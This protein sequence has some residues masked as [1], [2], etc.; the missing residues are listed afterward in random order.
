MAHMKRLDQL[1]ETAEFRVLL[2]RCFRL[3]MKSL[4]SKIGEKQFSSRRGLVGEWSTELR[5]ASYNYFTTEE[6]NLLQKLVFYP[7]NWIDVLQFKDSFYCGHDKV[8]KM[9]AMKVQE[10]LEEQEFGTVQNFI[11]IEQS[12]FKLQSSMESIKSLLSASEVLS[13]EATKFTPTNN[14]G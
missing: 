13:L 12:L 2:E 5:R 4:Q 7:Q 1:L 9:I 8:V 6:R 11:D 10:D 3:A 14:N